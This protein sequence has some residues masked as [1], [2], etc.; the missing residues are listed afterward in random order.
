M[1][2]RGEPEIQVVIMNRDSY[3]TLK[4]IIGGIHIMTILWKKDGI[5]WEVLTKQEDGFLNCEVS[6]S[7]EVIINHV[8]EFI[9]G[10][11]F[12]HFDPSVVSEARL[13]EAVT[14]IQDYLNTCHIVRRVS[15][16]PSL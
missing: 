11:K 15:K 6:M 7:D 2:E 3:S 8:R 16:S 14:I 12:P 1:V 4:L 10:A 5:A 13:N 9:H